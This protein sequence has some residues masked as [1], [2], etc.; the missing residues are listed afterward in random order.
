MKEYSVRGTYKGKRINDIVSANSKRQAKIKSGF[1]NGFGGSEMRGF[2][3]SRKV[4]V[5]AK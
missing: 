3:D 4:K 1:N 2:M 5:R